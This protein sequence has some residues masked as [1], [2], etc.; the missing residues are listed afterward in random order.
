MTFVQLAPLSAYIIAATNSYLY[1]FFLKL[2]ILIKKKNT[3]FAINKNVSTLN[4]QLVLS[5]LQCCGVI[6]NNLPTE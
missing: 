1:I 4:D 3:S 2:K 5:I 6:N